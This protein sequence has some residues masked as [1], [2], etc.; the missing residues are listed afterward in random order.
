VTAR[1]TPQAT[2][3]T[4]VNGPNQVSKNFD[5]AVINTLQTIYCTKEL[6]FCR[7]NTVTVLVVPPAP[8]LQVSRTGSR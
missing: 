3:G 7:V 8:S 6:P 4:Y 2:W 5:H 1:R